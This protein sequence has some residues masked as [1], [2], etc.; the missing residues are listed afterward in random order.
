M[1][2]IGSESNIG[3]AAITLGTVRLLKKLFPE[4]SITF[5]SL[6]DDPRRMRS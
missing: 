5:I 1:V 6:Y 3:I 2:N 4:S